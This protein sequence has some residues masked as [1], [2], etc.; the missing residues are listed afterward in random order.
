[1]YF[2]IYTYNFI[3]EEVKVIEDD[4][5]KKSL[6]NE[7]QVLKHFTENNSFPIFYRLFKRENKY[8][9]VK[10]LLGTNIEKIKKFYGKSLDVFTEGK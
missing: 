9:F 8:D 4:S 2:G 10:N 3:P 1:M 7:C 6:E 5:K